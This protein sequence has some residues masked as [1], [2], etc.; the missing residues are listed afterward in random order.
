MCTK[1][2]NHI[3][4]GFCD[5]VRQTDFVLL[6]HFLP[7][8][9]PNNPEN[10]NFEKIK[11]AYEDV[12][13]LYM[14]TKNDDHMVYASWDMGAT[15]TIFC[16]F[17]SFFAILPLFYHYLP[18]YHYI[19]HY[20]S[21]KLKILKK[22]RRY[23]LLCMCTIKKDS[24]DIRRNRQ[25]FLS[26]W[27]IFF[28]FIPLRNQKTKILKKWKKRKNNPGDIII[29]HLSTTNDNHMMYGSWD[30]EYNRQNLFSFWTI[31]CPFTEKS[32]FWKKKSGDIMRFHLCPTNDNHMMYGSLDIRC[33]GQSLLGTIFCLFDPPENM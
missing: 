8:Y 20:W 3:R 15:H 24:R 28:P 17:G 6:G 10:Q 19:P 32:K 31:F 16:H 33:K 29:L 30:M 25:K 4:H 7:F 13:I 27:V 12:I 23:F 2:H 26:F 5:R 21:Q 22:I 14:C 9:S 1:N 11:N 18:F